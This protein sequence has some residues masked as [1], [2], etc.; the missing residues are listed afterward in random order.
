MP[1]KTIEG[2]KL[3]S[4]LRIPTWP[5]SPFFTSFHH[6]E[7]VVLSTDLGQFLKTALLPPPFP[8]KQTFTELLDTRG[9]ENAF[10]SYTELDQCVVT[11]LSILN[12]L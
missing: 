7:G 1:M 3:G 9:I 12:F 5:V 6:V 11:I 8:A 2:V 4:Y 10:F